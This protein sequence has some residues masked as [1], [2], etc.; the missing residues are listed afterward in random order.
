PEAIASRSCASSWAR[1]GAPSARASAS[2]SSGAK[3]VLF[4]I[5]GLVLAAGP[6]GAYR[7]TVSTAPLSRPAAALAA[8]GA[9]AAVGSSF[10][11]LGGLRHYPEAGGQALRYVA[12][13][14]L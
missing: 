13:A 8:C 1:S 10:A 7:R 11:V 6:L 2:S 5:T 12:G 14:A 3:V 4:S 9:M